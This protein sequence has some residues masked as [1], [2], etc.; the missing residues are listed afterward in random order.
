MQHSWR[1][2]RVEY[3]IELREHF[4]KEE[5]RDLANISVGDVVNVADEKI[6]RCY[7]R[8]GRVIELITGKDGATRGAKVVA[9][10][11]Q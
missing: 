6:P 5:H 11:D 10:T 7:W 1:R 3:I 4:K 2:W 8:I 9:R